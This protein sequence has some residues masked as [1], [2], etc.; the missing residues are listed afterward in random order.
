MCRTRAMMVRAAGVCDQ[1]RYRSG[2]ASG[3]AA[4][5]EQPLPFAAVHL[6]AWIR[7]GGGVFAAHGGACLGRGTCTFP[8]GRIGEYF[9][10]P[11]PRRRSGGTL[12]GRGAV[13]EWVKLRERN[14]ALDLECY[15]LAA[16]YILGPALLKGLG[17]RAGRLAAIGETKAE[18]PLQA[19][20]LPPRPIV[21]LLGAPR[22]IPGGTWQVGGWRR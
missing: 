11:R 15:C 14:D 19:A 10:Q 3:W 9:E 17:E 16:L 8:T 5:A 13:K 6:C 2:E 20:A 1:G 7:G 4:D 12:K 18:Q 21:S 22:R